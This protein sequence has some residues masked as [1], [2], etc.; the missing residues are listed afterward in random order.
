[1]NKINSQRTWNFWI[2]KAEVWP[3]TCICRWYDHGPWHGGAKDGCS[4]VKSHCAWWTFVPLGKS[5]FSWRSERYLCAVC[6]NILIT[7]NFWFSSNLAVNLINTSKT[8]KYIYIVFSVLSNQLT[9]EHAHSGNKIRVR[10]QD[11]LMLSNELLEKE[12]R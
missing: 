9:V 11:Q 3:R 8:L 1:M 4:H 10:R 5:H 7:A 2:K 6:W 12:H